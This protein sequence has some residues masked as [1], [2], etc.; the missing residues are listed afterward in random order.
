MVGIFVTDY[1][2]IRKGN[3][4]VESL[5]DPNGRYWYWH[6]YNWR[7]FASFVVAVILPIPGFAA[8]FGHDLPVVWTR[9]YDVGWLIGC[10]LSS[11]CYFALCFVGD[12]ATEEKNMGFEETVGLH[13]CN[14]SEVGN[15]ETVHALESV[16]P[17]KIGG[18]DL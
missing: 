16:Q 15:G 7:A 14:G 1:F 6:G 4:W 2:V 3:I 10:V 8:L 11:F 12:F 5:Y 13:L 17:E 18:Y 9:I